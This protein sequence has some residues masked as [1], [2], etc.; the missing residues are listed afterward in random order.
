[1]H[2]PGINLMMPSTPYDAK[3]CIL[4]AL[5]LDSPTVILEHRSLYDSTG[6]VPENMYQIDIKKARSVLQGGDITIVAVSYMV[7]EAMRAAMALKKQGISAEIIDP[8][9]FNPLDEDAIIRSVRKTGRLMVCDTSWVSCGVSSEI[10]GMIAEKAYDSLKAPVKRIGVKDCPAP[11]SRT[12]E[13]IF[14]S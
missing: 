14:L 9:V 10:A 5:K 7:R 4:T 8:R 13:T 1:M 6:R 11:V 2:F 12:L 3:G